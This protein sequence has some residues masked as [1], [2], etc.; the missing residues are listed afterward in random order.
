MQRTFVVVA[1]LVG[2]LVPGVLRA[3]PCAALD[4][5]QKK[6]AEGIMAQVYPHDCCDDTLAAC[7]AADKPSR[8]VKRLAAAVCRRVAAD[9][10]PED[11]TRALERRG[12]SMVPVGPPAVIDTS[13]SPFAGD[14][15]A[16]VQVV[17]YACARCPFCSKIVPA[18]HTCV[19]GGRLQGK[20]Q[21][22]IR[23]FPIRGHAHSIESGL[24]VEAANG[25][26]Q[27]W[28]Y[29]LKVYEG[30]DSFSL[31]ALT[32]WAAEVGL[33]PATFE[34]ATTDPKTRER[35]V[36]AKREGLSHRVAATPTFFVNGK[37]YRGDLD[38]EAFWD[39]LEEEHERVTGVLCQPAP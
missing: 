33:D 27:F 21:L 38:P 19:T 3:D 32:R 7:L 23:L 1:V 15:T 34:A 25:L 36:A 24:A 28:A 30:F 10:K 17:G 5:A 31:E 8:L 4:A 26:G 6:T 22:A 14:K 11:V 39:A 9:Q 18:L 2:L 16:P 35:V 37:V 13:G 12:T 20:A 29:L